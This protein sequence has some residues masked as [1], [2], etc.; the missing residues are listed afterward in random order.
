ML[1]NPFQAFYDD[2]GITKLNYL[3]YLFLQLLHFCQIQEYLLCDV[4]QVYHQIRD[5]DNMHTPFIQKTYTSQPI[6]DS[7]R[8]V[9]PV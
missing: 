8:P 5:Y 7:N 1:L 3:H 6:S 9:I 2:L 4:L